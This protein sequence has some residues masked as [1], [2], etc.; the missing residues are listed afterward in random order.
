[1]VGRLTFQITAEGLDFLQAIPRRVVAIGAAA[2][3]EFSVLAL[4]SHFTFVALA[5]PSGDL[6]VAGDTL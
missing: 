5:A 3:R 4:Q 6:G 1:M 2:H